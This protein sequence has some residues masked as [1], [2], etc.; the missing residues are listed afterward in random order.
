MFVPNSI[1][2]V[3]RPQTV[4][5]LQ[6]A[7]LAHPTI[8]TRC[9]L[10]RLHQQQKYQSYWQTEQTGKIHWEIFL[11]INLPT[12]SSYIIYELIVVG[13]YLRPRFIMTWV[14]FSDHWERFLLLLFFAAF[15]RPWR[16]R[17]FRMARSAKS[18]F[19]ARSHYIS[20]G[21]RHDVTVGPFFI[22][23]RLLLTGSPGS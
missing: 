19:S 1:V 5:R 4:D 2:V 17:I 11:T 9:P 6:A 16:W 13:L 22:S 23:N 21:V 3:Y 8:L 7:D 20:V 10:W 12:M 14:D 18:R 15:R